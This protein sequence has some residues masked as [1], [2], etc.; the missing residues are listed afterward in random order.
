[1]PKQELNGH[2][3]TREGLTADGS[4]TVAEMTEFRE[5]R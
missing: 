1:M 4:F 5:I 2:E 3:L